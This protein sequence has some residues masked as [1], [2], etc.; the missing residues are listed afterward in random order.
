[1]PIQ[2]A[3]YTVTMFVVD[4][5][6]SM[7]KMRDVPLPAVEGQ[8]RQTVQMTN[9]A[10]ALHIVK[11][12]IQEMIFHG[13]KT[14]KCGVILAG[15]DGT[16]N[17]INDQRPDEYHNVTEYIPIAQP[18]PD[19]L[20]KISRISPSNQDSCDTLEGVIVAL[21]A[22]NR[23][24]GSKATWTRK[25]I[26]VTD[27][28]HP[29]QQEGYKDVI[30]AM[31][32]AKVKTSI[33]GIDFD[34]EERGYVYKEK[35]ETKSLIERWWREKFVKRLDD[36]IV[37]NCDFALQE[38]A[39][40]E[41]K[42]VRSTLSNTVLRF[43]DM[44]MNKDQS[45]ELRVRTSKATSIARPPPLKKFARARVENTMEWESQGVDRTTTQFV[46][47]KHRTDFFIKADPS[48]DAAAHSSS[49]GRFGIGSGLQSNASE[50]P[51]KMEDVQDVKLEID[52]D[53]VPL[54]LQPLAMR[55]T[56]TKPEPVVT[57]N[58]ENTQIAYKYGSTYIPV[59][60]ADF[61]TLQTVKGLDILGFIPQHKFRREWSMGEVYYIWGDDQSGKMQLAFSSI[62]RA[63]AQEELCAIIR[64]VTLNNSAPKVG[65]A[66]P[67]ILEKADC[68][69]WVQMPFAED[70]RNFAFQSLTRLY[71]KKG[72]QITDHPNIPTDGMIEVMEKYIDSMDLMQIEKDEEGNRYPWFDTL[73]S[74][75]P[76]LHRVKQALFHAAVA[77]SL[78]TDPLPPPHPDLLNYFDWHPKVAKRSK[79]AIEE[80]RKRLKIKHV[81]PKTAGARNEAP[82]VEGREE[83]PL[84]QGPAPPVRKEL[85]AP[86]PSKAQAREG[87]SDTDATEDEEEAPV[88]VRTEDA[89]V[90]PLDNVKASPSK[91]DVDL[92]HV[93]QS[94]QKSDIHFK[95][96][97][98]DE[99]VVVI[100]TVH[101]L[102]DFRAALASD[103]D[104]VSEAVSQLADVIK[105]LAVEGKF[106]NKRKNELLEAMA[107]LRET[108]LKEDEFDQWNKFLQELKDI[109]LSSKPGNKPFWEL[110]R[111]KGQTMTLIGKSEAIAA[112]AKA[113]AARDAAK[114]ATAQK[115]FDED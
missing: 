53:G 59:D 84:L 106:P 31:N 90:A 66:V 71:N 1:M 44:E 51:P 8:P 46:Q 57:V 5:S 91:R 3:G 111:S 89:E 94:P 39:R 55:N 81:P 110:V 72:K 62:V 78:A 104:V 33:V 96:E 64:M 38:C 26:V 25:L 112:G 49:N 35:S 37:I 23:E 13:R 109:C 45:F 20:A 63:M 108:C 54:D 16:K 68:L 10:W 28:E 12:K 21:D 36:G 34:D 58:D 80:C 41:V 19:T 65:I 27:G 47:V 52:E 100:G 29:I 61:E 83:A 24:L 43:G 2:R 73:Y 18:T 86:S 14:D 85:M 40:P 97:E 22:Q 48:T 60:K 32:D 9:L 103:D 75:N 70:N 99:A 92:N 98:E 76:A 74:Y 107:A 67:R 30:Q 15:T 114:D 101:P 115:F 95:D 42:E 105:S 93:K 6:R 11:L 102:E 4:V 77:D 56:E 87:D 79:G 113:K 7:G 50:A 82:L 17:F 88:L 69:L